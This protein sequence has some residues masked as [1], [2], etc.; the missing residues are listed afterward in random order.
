MKPT[1]GLAGLLEASALRYP[2]APAV[3][4]AEG[5][6]ISYAELDA[7]AGRVRDRL[8]QLGV[9]PGD[10]VGLRLRKSVDGIITIF[11]VL[12]AGAA[13]VPVDAESPA[14]RGAYI[15]DN[16]QV[17]VVVTETALE[18][19]LTGELQRLGA[20]PVVLALDTA[21]GPHVGMQ[22]L[23]DALDA[24]EKAPRVESVS[25]GPDDIAYILYT[26]GSTGN[27]KGVVLSHGNAA[28]F[29]DWCSDTFEPRPTDA[30][31]SHAPFHFDL[32]ILDIYVPIKHGA[33]LALFGEALGK[34]PMKL[35]AAISSEKIS[36]WYSTPSI[37]NFLATYGK[38]DRYDYSSLRIVH[39]AGEVF[40][41]PQ[42]KAVRG[43]WKAPR[44]F[45][46][47]GPTETNVCTFYEVPA[48]D[49]WTGMSTFPIGRICVPN[50][51]WVVDEHTQTVKRGDAGE[52]L[53]SGPNVMQGY[54]NLDEQNQRVFVTDETGRRWYRTGDIVTEDERGEYRYLGRRDRMVKRRG[55]RVELG[56]IEA[57]LARHPQIKE[58][59]VVAVA[60]QDSGVKISAFVS[61]QDGQPL[62]IIGLKKLSSESLPPYMIPDAFKLVAALPRTSTNKVDLQALKAQA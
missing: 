11:G 42:F 53:I 15:L 38:L 40:P 45:N 23:L 46:L 9:R 7:L 18:T 4:M 35:A 13:Y 2:E 21:A 57:A 44:F 43:I 30:F 32:S 41:I 56:E 17:K 49:S 20:S 61:C 12:K 50:R 62:T 59:A 5:P 26:S 3:G 29:V 27:P 33:R 1:T 47:Y 28:S 14:A 52:L 8:W 6:R 58:A 19:A 55:Y 16:C 25:S 54:W 10:R 37:L 48:D 60:D 22:S 24:R 34:D 31:S 39:F 36:I 51:G